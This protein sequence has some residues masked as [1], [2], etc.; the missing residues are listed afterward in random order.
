MKLQEIMQS[1]IMYPLL[2][3]P[4]GNDTRASQVA[5]VVKNSTATA[6]NIRDMGNFYHRSCRTVV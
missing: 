2:I 6:G 5:L 3:V 4:Q 1:N